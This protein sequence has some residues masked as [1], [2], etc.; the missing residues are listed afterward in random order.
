MK[1]A[2]EQKVAE[3]WM[4]SEKPLEVDEIISV[5]QGAGR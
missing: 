3:G 5:E 4:Q 2:T 1:L